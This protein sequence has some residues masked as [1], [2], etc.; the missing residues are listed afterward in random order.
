MDDEKFVTVQF[1]GED[2][3]HYISY[4][5]AMI[6][7]LKTIDEKNTVQAI[8][9]NVSDSE[10][11]IRLLEH[12]QGAK[13]FADVF[14]KDQLGIKVDTEYLDGIISA[15][16]NQIASLRI[17]L[18]E[19]LTNSIESSSE[20]CVYVLRE[21]NGGLY[22][23]GFSK[24]FRKRLSQIRSG[25]PYKVDVVCI[26]GSTKPNE[27]ESF[28]HAYFKEK[29]HKGEWFNL[30]NTEISSLLRIATEVVDKRKLP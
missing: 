13:R 12:A 7:L 3:A 4:I 21:S 5:S 9:K 8:I 1:Q 24:R 20:S 28:L 30:D 15:L 11:L 17:E 27:L 29:K 26:I 16:G 6:G 23:I 2:A 22:K 10:N 14:W 18:P 19:A 25:I